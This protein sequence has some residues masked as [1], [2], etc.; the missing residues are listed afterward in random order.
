[1]RTRTWPLHLVTAL[2]AAATF[3]VL[4]AIVAL[5]TPGHA[6]AAGPV[7]AIPAP[8]GSQWA[9]LAGYNTV[10][11]SVEDGGDIYAI[12][13]H[14]TDAPTEHTPVLAP[15][16]GT[17]RFVSSSCAT[18]RDAAGVSVLMC[19]ILVPQSLRNATVT[20]GQRIGVLAPAG[21]AGNNGFPHI[22]IALSLNGPRPF[23][24]EYAIEGIALPP[25]G[26]AN[27][28]ADTAF[29]STN[30]EAPG[31]DAG[32]DISVRPGAPVTLR[33]AATNPHGA[34]LSY[35]WTQT[36]GTTVALTPSGP[37]ATFTAPARTGTLQFRV[38]V[39][40]GSPAV[41][42]DTVS[43]LV[44]TSS[45]T[46]PPAP[47]VQTGRFA[48]TPVFTAGGQALVV[49]RTGNVEQLEA[50]AR[51]AQAGGV[52]VQDASGAYRLLILDGAA[53]IRQDFVARFPGGFPGDIAVTLVR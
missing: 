52:W 4:F 31:V 9:V 18:I 53:F 38:A 2:G 41:A 28:Y 12:D 33:A 47:V 51:S 15:I 46:P 13:L 19:H 29:V 39:S 50:A 16:S 6:W 17:I 20:R 40:D 25:T 24:G 49:F 7:F 11:H 36:G 10:T 45:P 37:T 32:S 42:T 43:V 5:T 35:T 34:G 44:S 21:Q 23:I 26:D 14:R 48:A 27:A 22:H 8:A 1:M 30:R 3:A